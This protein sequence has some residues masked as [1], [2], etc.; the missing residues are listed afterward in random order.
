[1]RT[2]NGLLRD[3][4]MRVVV[5]YGSTILGVATIMAIEGVNYYLAAQPKRWAHML[6]AALGALLAFLKVRLFKPPVE[7]TRNHVPTSEVDPGGSI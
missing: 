4:W 6:A 3:L 1:M 5:Y 2:L 7:V